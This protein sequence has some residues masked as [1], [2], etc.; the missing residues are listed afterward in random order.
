MKKWLLS[1][2]LPGI[3]SVLYAQPAD[4]FSRAA[5]TIPAG[6]KEGEDYLPGRIICKTSDPAVFSTPL[7]Q[8]YLQTL[9]AATPEP[10]FKGAEK[11]RTEYDTYGRR[12][13]DLS[14]IYVI[15]FDPQTPVRSVAEKLR[16]SA[17]FLYVQPHYI[18]KPFSD[19]QVQLVP[20]D[21][22]V[23][24]QWYL[25]KIR[26]YDAWN[27]STGDTSMI[28]AITDG[29][30]NWTNPD[31]VNYYINYNDPTDGIDN[32]G[33][34]WIDNSVGW[35]TGD[36][37]SDPTAYCGS[38]IHGTV[39]NGIAAARTGNGDGIAGVAYQC[40]F[41]PV[42]IA[43][44]AGQWIGGEAAIFYAAQQ[45]I[46]IINCS[47]GSPYYSPVQDDVVQYAAVNRGCLIVAAAGN[48]SPTATTPYYPATLENV[49]AVTGTDTSDIKVGDAISGASYYPGVDISAPGQSIYATYGSGYANAG[50]GTSY[51]APMVSGAA[52]LTMTALPGITAMQTEAL[53][54]QTAFPHDTLPM[55]LAYKG[56]IGKGRLDMHNAVLG[57]YAGPSF[58]FQQRSYTDHDDDLFAAGDTVYLSGTFFNILST[59]GAGTQAILRSNSPWIEMIDSVF[60]IGSV[61]VFS[62]T[63]NLADPYTFR[64]LPGCP[65]NTLAA[66]EWEWTDGS[67]SDRQFF[68][69]IVG[70]NY[71][72]ITENKV[73]TSI[74][75]RG[76]WGFMDEDARIGLGLKEENGFQ[77][78]LTGS[79]FVADGPTRVSDAWFSQSVVP[80]D[81]DFQATVP[82][83]AIPSAPGTFIAEGIMNDSA[84]PSPT[85]L[86]I[87]YRT[88]AIN[89]VGLDKFVT[90]YYT[91]ENTGTDTLNNVFAGITSYWNVLNNHYY[92]YTNIAAFDT[93]RRMGYARNTSGSS[94]FAALKLLSYDGIT[95]YAF[96]PDGASGSV[97]ILDGFS[98]A[99]KWNTLSGSLVRNQSSAGNAATMLGSGPFLIQPGGKVKLAFALILGSNL[100][101]LQQYADSAQALY[102]SRWNTWTGLQSSDWHT[103]QNWSLLSIPD[104]TQPVHI[105]AGTPYSPV[106][107]GAGEALDL[108][109]QNGN[110]LHIQNGAALRVQEQTHV[111]GLLYSMYGAQFIQGAHSNLSGNGT[112]RFGYTASANAEEFLSIPLRQV[113][114]ATFA[115]GISGQ[116]N[117]NAFALSD[118]LHMIV[119]DCSLPLFNPSSP[120]GNIAGYDNAGGA[121]CIFEGYTIRSSGD[122]FAGKGYRVRLQS[123]DSVVL[124]NFPFN[125]ELSIPTVLPAGGPNKGWQLLANPY[126]SNISWNDFLQLHNGNIYGGAI[127]TDGSHVQLADIYTQSY[128]PPFKAFWV[129]ADTLQTTYTSLF[130]NDIRHSGLGYDTTLLSQPFHFGTDIHFFSPSGHS[131][132]V[133]IYI[134]PASTYNFD[135]GKELP[136]V[137]TQAGTPGIHVRYNTV[138]QTHAV[139]AVPG[140]NSATVFPLGI[141]S[142]ESG[143]FRFLLRTKGLLPDS[144]LM[145]FHD[146]QSGAYTGISGNDTIDITL[147]APAENT[148]FQIRF[149]A[150]P[151]F[152]V[153]DA[154]CGNNDGK[155]QVPATCGYPLQ[156]VLT[157]IQGDT[158]R[159]GTPGNAGGIIGGLAQGTYILHYGAGNY[160]YSDSLTIG[161]MS[162]VTAGFSAPASTYINSPVSFINTSTGSSS[163]LWDFGDGMLS[164][165]FSPTH[166]Y[167]NNGTYQVSLVAENAGC[168]D[169]LVKEILVYGLGLG[170]TAPNNGLAIQYTNGQL[171]LYSGTALSNARLVLY[172]ASG[173]IL[174]QENNVYMDGNSYYALAAPLRPG[175]Y[176]ISLYS[177][178]QKVQSAKVCITN[179]K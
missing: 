11:P 65:D 26:A 39:V 94:A 113:P 24:A 33:D 142:P 98:S 92:D 114:L 76:R 84:G 125:K 151:E 97:N 102:D 72:N 91:L 168:S 69:C 134:D 131:D 85:G 177:A 101:D 61:P 137:Y 160:G 13:A 119:D 75:S 12:M 71:I 176:F 118:G 74:G 54:K 135:P 170:E 152:G 9:G 161:G 127:Y 1:I 18:V 164:V 128:I 129:F 80:F 139:L 70:Q 8:Q 16:L 149:C 166:S 20:N 35:N 19:L 106:L 7:I 132:Q 117:A 116:V 29:G 15:D 165:Q 100:A 64:V 51:A 167:I 62:N 17:S 157:D 169:T 144:L 133:R 66:L 22:Q 140:V 6:L 44:S 14:G 77:Y 93:L 150:R 153:T 162:Q 10:M 120:D 47:W 156:Y 96:N 158:L 174:R 145:F 36:N 63:D 110:S 57:N 154:G 87:H 68:S 155:I 172:D 25:N 146:T 111:N 108:R 28:I 38:C 95:H 148:R 138:P 34:G 109:I 107:Q 79:F 103:A 178:G 30:Q 175:Y 143:S 171:Q 49:L 89:Q 136:D 83:H 130:G 86:R 104:T 78:S 48:G 50:N 56:R 43:N 21:P 41:T 58:T 88:E 173:R 123:G 52:A 126:P 4:N 105:P 121:A 2:C 55:N 5:Y 82:A 32:D 73:H 37:N 147:N 81:N 23:N 122:L 90:L 179:S 59:S 31:L 141:R 112:Y 60:A 46:K 99:E 163:Q 3:F 53:L 40:R 27:T 42:K 67:F 115:A 124:E 45:N 159:Q